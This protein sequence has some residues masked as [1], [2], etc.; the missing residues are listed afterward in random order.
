MGIGQ[1][2]RNAYAYGGVKEV[3]RKAFYHRIYRMTRKQTIR[4]VSHA[5]TEYGLNRSQRDAH[6]VVSLTSF[7]PRFPYLGPC[8]KSLVLQDLKPDKI[9]MY[10]GNDCTESDITEEM[11]SYEQYGVEFRIDP[12]ENLMPHKKYYYAMQQFPDSII[13][14]ADDDVIYPA[15]WLRSLYES[16]QQ[17]PS[18]ISARRVHFIQIKNGKLAPYDH[19]IDQIRSVRRPSKRLI[20]IGNGG[21]LYP[22]GCLDEKA[23]AVEDIKS[24]CLRNDDLWLKCNEVRLNIPVVW[25]RNWK[26]EPAAIHSE[27]TLSSGN[28][29]TGKNDAVLRL[30]MEHFSLTDDDFND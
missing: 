11:R 14:T 30:L 16:Y 13:V 8:L 2:L 7:P 3:F 5:H 23:F 6:I 4:E 29:F 22:P 19:W 21:V 17:Y 24:L 10:L 20:A 25:V 15:N 28:I 26:V 9:I 18:V 27:M 1:R 12:D